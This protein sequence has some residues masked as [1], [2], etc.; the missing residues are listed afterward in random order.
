[1]VWLAGGTTYLVNCWLPAT[2]AC[3][4]HSFLKPHLS[5]SHSPV[6]CWTVLVQGCPHTVK[7]KSAF[8][9]KVQEYP[10]SEV[11]ECP[12]T[13]KFKSAHIQSSPQT[14]Y[15]RQLSAYSILQQQAT[16]SKPS[17]ESIKPQDYW[18]GRYLI[19]QWTLWLNNDVGNDFQGVGQLFRSKNTLLGSSTTLNT[20]RQNNLQAMVL[21]NS[22][23]S[24]G[25]EIEENTFLKWQ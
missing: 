10:H 11:Q 17:V 3:S 20:S 7:S 12:H 13:V 9:Q 25:V 6:W 14:A 24:F 15:R 4:A 16:K 1:M 18:W 22:L 23:G 21:N 2:A 19:E 8:K 5:F